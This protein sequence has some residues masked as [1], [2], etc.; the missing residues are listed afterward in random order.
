MLLFWDPWKTDVILNQDAQTDFPHLQ[1][2]LV[3][4][5]N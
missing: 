5:P 2:I 3:L 4:A 1:I